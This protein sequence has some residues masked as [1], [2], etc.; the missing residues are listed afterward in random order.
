MTDRLEKLKN[1]T[2]SQE[3]KKQLEQDLLEFKAMY[4]YI[5]EEELI[6]FESL[7]QENETSSTH[8]THNTVKKAI[9]KRLTKLII[10]M[11]FVTLFLFTL[12]YVAVPKMIDSFYFN[13]LVGKTD[14]GYS[15]FETYAYIE[16]SLFPDGPQL[17]GIDTERT[18]IATYHI[19]TYYFDEF[20]RQLK[21]RQMTLSKNKLTSLDSGTSHIMLSSSLG[22]E[23]SSGYTTDTDY[24][25][26]QNIMKRVEQLP[27]STMLKVKFYFDEPKSLEQLKKIAS[28]TKDARLLATSIN[29]DINDDFSPNGGLGIKSTNPYMTQSQ[30]YQMVFIND[31]IDKDYPNINRAIDLTTI[32]EEELK[33]VFIAKLSYLKDHPKGD[34]HSHLKVED[35]QAEGILKVDREKQIKLLQ[36]EA[37]VFDTMT[38]SIPKKDFN[39]F[40]EHPETHFFTIQDVNYFSLVDVSQ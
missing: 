29:P 40:I 4:D 28:T 23:Q 1:N 22:I 10:L 18:G 20:S 3:E 36:E 31:D 8:T 6:A 27:D 5:T 32:T 9:N 13:P 12:V 19:K 26:T 37:L 16:N 25:Q 33:D 15:D 35:P 14:K 7:E 17:I 11:S 38:M 39:A 24:P 34:L 21:D 2:L 30:L